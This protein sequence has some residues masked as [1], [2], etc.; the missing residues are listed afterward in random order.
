MLKKL[1]ILI[2]LAVAGTTSFAQ[3][4]HPDLIGKKIAVAIKQE[5]QLKSKTYTNDEDIIIAGGMAMPV[6]FIRVEKNI[7]NLIVQYIFSEKDS[8]IREIEYEWD[9]RN[10]DKSDHIVKPISFDKALI[11]RYNSLLAYFTKKYG[12]G[13]AKGD[14]TDLTRID[15]LGGL[16]RTDKWNANGQV[17]VLMYTA[18]SNYYRSQPYVTTIPTHRIRVYLAKPR[19]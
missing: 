1:F 14:L 16:S 15:S 11:E 2:T 8:I 3:I 13:T 5:Q 9:V 10:F 18:I 19:K 17:D 12:P 4:V 6:R 7:P